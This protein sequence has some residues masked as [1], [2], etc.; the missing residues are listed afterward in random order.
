MWSLRIRYRWQ[1]YGVLPEV[2]VRVLSEQY[3]QEMIFSARRITEKHIRHCFGLIRQSGYR[4]N[5]S[6]HLLKEFSWW[7]TVVV[8][9]EDLRSDA[10]SIFECEMADEYW[11]IKKNAWKNKE[12]LLTHTDEYCI[13]SKC[14][15]F[16]DTAWT[17]APVNNVFE[18]IPY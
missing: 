14:V 11:K 6:M 18:D 7:N 2:R 16:K 17:N 10:D 4:K 8:W 3:R 9:T 15:K 5:G 1:E 12:S 13:M